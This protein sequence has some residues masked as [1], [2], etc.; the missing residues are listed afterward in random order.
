M[1]NYINWIETSQPIKGDLLPGEGNAVANYQTTASAA[2]SSA[3]PRGAD[4]AS[5]WAT[6]A[7]KV[8]ASNLNLDKVRVSSAEYALPANTVMTVFNITEATTITMTDL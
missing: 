7:C 6:V 8:V 1:T 5:V 2:T 3:A 4:Y